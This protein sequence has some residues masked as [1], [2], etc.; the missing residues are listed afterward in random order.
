MLV[1]EQKWGRQ[2]WQLHPWLQASPHPWG[3]H[4]SSLKSQEL[5]NAMPLLL[6]T[7]VRRWWRPTD[8]PRDSVPRPSSERTYKFE[9]RLSELP[10]LG[11]ISMAAGQF[12]GSRSHPSCQFVDSIN[13][14]TEVELNCSLVIEIDKHAEQCTHHK[15]TREWIFTNWTHPW[16]SVHIKIYSMPSTTSTGE[17]PPCLLPSHN[18]AF[19]HWGWLQL[20]IS[21]STFLVWFFRL[22]SSSVSHYADPILELTR[23]LPTFRR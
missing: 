19:P 9:N 5:H 23:S 10:C 6:K 18:H 22:N 21:E 12:S 1:T 2:V 4:S 8:R 20:N 16:S 11:L 17:L 15:H 7:M 13:S 14:H 3:L